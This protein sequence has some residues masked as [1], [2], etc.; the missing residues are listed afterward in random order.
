MGCDK[1]L[2]ID[3]S[4][5]L[6]TV[7]AKDRRLLPLATL[8]MHINSAALFESDHASI[9]RVGALLSSFFEG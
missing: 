9:V 7:G 2:P 4:I 6:V 3:S 5:T 1:R 8:A